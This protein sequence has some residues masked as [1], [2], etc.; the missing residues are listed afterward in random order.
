MF[1]MALETHWLGPTCYVWSD[2]RCGGSLIAS[3]EKTLG[4]CKL[5]CE[6]SKSCN[7]IEFKD[8]TVLKTS[9]GPCFL[10]NCSFPVPAPCGSNDECKRGVSEEP[11]NELRGYYRAT[12]K[13]AN[14]HLVHGLKKK[15]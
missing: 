14:M 11:D 6:N 12:G 1:D 15:R 13:N 2:K 7:A 8:T 10:R 5:A 9:E 3:N 4:D